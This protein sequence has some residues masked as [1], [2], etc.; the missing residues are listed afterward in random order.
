MLPL[1]KVRTFRLLKL[2]ILCSL[3]LILS[4]EITLPL[5]DHDMSAYANVEIGSPGQNFTLLFDPG[6]SVTWVG[7]NKKYHETSSSKKTSQNVSVAYGSGRFGGYEYVDK[8][9]F[10]GVSFNQNIGV[11][12]ESE[13]IPEG[14]DGLMAVGPTNLSI[15]TLMPNEKQHVPAILDNLIKEHMVDD[16]VMTIN[17]TS[18]TFG[19]AS[20]DN[21][22]YTPVTTNSPA[23]NF[24]GLDLSFGLGDTPLSR[25]VSGII[26]HGSTLNMLP[27]SAFRKFIEESGA[28]R[29]TATG[30]PVL[31][32]C[33]ELGPLVLDMG[34]AK[35]SIPA[36]Q[37][38]W[39]ADKYDLIQGKPGLCYLALGATA[40]DESS[41]HARPNAKFRSSSVYRAITGGGE[42]VDFILGYNTLKHRSV[43]LDKD[44]SRIGFSD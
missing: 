24:W 23:S 9:S 17:G 44:G 4:A 37:Y 22:Q 32:S 14:V 11:A 16:A 30:L 18:I 8:I 26:D 34:S 1:L 38:R 39:P 43:V 41:F 27:A 7:A 5:Q 42:D 13:G 33:D 6:S 20:G 15:G 2:D 25:K 31:D 28:K 40:S 29:D 10:G 36:E 12:V 21:L 35:I 19:A 3:L